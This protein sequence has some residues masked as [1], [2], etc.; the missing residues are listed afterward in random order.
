MVSIKHKLAKHQNLEESEIRYLVYEYGIK[1][2]YG[3]NH[4]WQQ[5]AT[6]LID[7]NNQ[8]YIVHWMSPLTELQDSDF[9]NQPIPVRET[10]RPITITMTEWL[11]ENNEVIYASYGDT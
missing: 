10:T 3:E 8:L 11:D 6:T 1:T 9:Y 2:F 4:R 5:E 7:F